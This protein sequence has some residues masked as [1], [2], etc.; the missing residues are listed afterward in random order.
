MASLKPSKFETKV[1][2]RDV[3]LLFY[4]KFC[5]KSMLGMMAVAIVTCQIKINKYSNNLKT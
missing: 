2:R 3:F 1:F 4:F 5:F